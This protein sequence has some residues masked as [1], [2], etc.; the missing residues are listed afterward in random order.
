MALDVF[1]PAVADWFTRAFDGP[2]QVQTQAWPLIAAGEHVLISAPT[3]SGKTLAA[4]LYGLDRLAA[5]PLPDKQRRV[6]LLYVSPLKALSHDVDRNLRAPLAGITAAIGQGSLLPDDRARDGSLRAEKGRDRDAI[7][8]ALRTGDTP[9]RERAA[10]R[11]RPP[12]V[13][14]TTPES[15]FLMLTSGAREMLTGV[16]SLIIDEIH[17]VAGTKRGSHMAL[18]LER[19]SALREPG[20][21]GA[22]SGD[23]MQRIGLS[24]TQNPLEEIGRFLVGP[25]RSCRIVET[26]EKKKMDLQIRVPVESMAEL[27]LA[28]AGTVRRPETDGIDDTTGPA[29]GDQLEPEGGFAP[30][31]G[32]A[33]SV[34]AGD[35]D[36]DGAGSAV[37]AGASTGDAAGLDPD[38]LDLDPAG[39]DDLDLDPGA[40]DAARRGLEAKGAADDLDLDPAGD[41]LEPAAATVDGDDLDD[42]GDDLDPS[43]GGVQLADDPLEPGGDPTHGATRNSIWPAMYPEILDLVQEHRSTIVFVNSRRSAERLALRLNE[44]AESRLAQ[45]ALEAGLGDPNANPDARWDE[46]P[47]EARKRKDSDLRRLIA[48]RDGVV[49][50]EDDPDEDDDDPEGAARERELQARAE[51]AGKA[52]TWA[53]S[54]HHDPDEEI[55]LPGPERH[56]GIQPP[57]PRKPPPVVP[58]QARSS[59]PGSVAA[60]GARRVSAPG[61]EE[62]LRSEAIAAGLAAGLGPKGVPTRDG[63]GP[64]GRRGAGSHPAT[65]PNG[66]PRDA[67]SGGGIAGSQNHVTGVGRPHSDHYGPRDD[68]Q[69][70]RPAPTGPSAV[71]VARAHHGSLSREEREVVEELLKAGKLPCLVA[72]SSLELGIDMGAVDLVLQIESPKSV[73]A[74]LQRIGRAGHGVGETAKGRI[75]PKFRADLLE[76]AVVVR[77]MREGLIEPTVV[78]KNALDVLAQQI[79]AIAASV[80]SDTETTDDDAEPAIAVDDVFA[81][82]T[83][84]YPYADLPREL[85]ERTLDMLD[86]RYPSQDFAELRPRVVWDRVGQTIRPRKG[87]GRLAI[88]NAGTIPDRGMYRVVLP[89]GRRV[90]ELDEEMVYEARAGQTFLLG[91]STWRIEEIGRDKVVVTPAPGAPGA[92]PFW[93][94]DQRGRP[95]ALGE[96][97]GAF[98]RWAVGEDEATLVRDYDLDPLAAR[99]L[100]DFLTEQQDAT[101]VIPSDQTLVIE[102]FKDEIGDWRVCLLSP[103]GGRV[104]AA[105]GLAASRRIRDEM[106]L[107]AD[108]IWSDDGII[109]H[110]PDIDDTGG[111]GVS[112]GDDP[113]EDGF[114]AGK[115]ASA[116]ADAG[117]GTPVGDGDDAGAK[118]AG[119]SGVD[120]GLSLP[121]DGGRG[122]GAGWDRV[123][124]LLVPEPEEVEDLIVSEL[125][126]SALFG[127]RFREN[128][129]RA[130][131][132]PKARPGKR[133][134]L[135]QQRLKAQSLLEVAQTFP[136]F[137][138]ILETYRECLRDVLDVPGLI[139]LLSKLQSREITIVEVETGTASPMA[140]SLLFDYIATYMYE[141]D[142]PN[143]ERRAAALSLDRDLLRELLG[144]D[145]LRDLLDEGALAQLEAD[146]Q[147]RSPKTRARNADALGEVLRRVGDLTDEEI[148]DRVAIGSLSSAAWD[149]DGGRDGRAGGRSDG[150]DGSNGGGPDGGGHATDGDLARASAADGRGPDGAPKDSDIADVGSLE[151][152]RAAATAWLDDLERQRRAIRM[153][154]GGEQRWIAADDAGLYRDALGAVPPGGLPEVF[155][156]DVRDPLRRLVIR[157]AATHGPFVDHELHARYGVDPTAVLRELLREDELVRGEIR[158]GGTETEHCDPEVLRRLRRMSLAVL[159]QEIEPADPRALVSFSQTWQGVDRYRPAGAGPDRLREVLVPLQGLALPVELWEHEVLPRRLG[160]YSPSWLDGLCASGEVVW[161]GAGALGRGGGK[162]AFYFREDSAVIGP[163]TGRAARDASISLPAAGAPMSAGRRALESG[164]PDGSPGVPGSGGAA[165]GPNGSPRGTGPGGQ[166]DQPGP[167]GP[168]HDALRRLLAS[169][170]MFFSDVLGAL[171]EH[172]AHLRDALWDLIWAGEVTCDVFAPLRAGRAGMK[173]QKPQPAAARS[174]IG[175]RAGG[176][177][178]FG[179]RPTGAQT[180]STQGRFSLTAPLFV[181]LDG[182]AVDPGLRRRTLAELLLERHGIVTREHVKAEGIAGG[183]STLYDSFGALETLGVCRRGYFVEGL[184]GAQF[185]LPGAVERLR[186]QAVPDVHGPDGEVNAVDSLG[187]PLPATTLDATDPAQPYGTLLPWPELPAPRGDREEGARTTQL[188]RPSTANEPRPQRAQGAR[189]VLVGPDPILFVDRSGKALQVLVHYDD[190]RLP[191]AFAALVEA[192]QTGKAGSLPRKGLQLERIDGLEVIGHPLEPLLVPA[193]FRSAPTKYLARA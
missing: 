66:A 18:T 187:R 21:P 64:D 76:C 184:G 177:R 127:A 123:L 68:T 84:A 138:I 107:E 48:T 151:E 80:D 130:L 85:F 12:D 165:A 157:Y 192:I 92:V 102:R 144:Q 28:P 10:M 79:V 154:I 75:F 77:R 44:L 32:T 182:G 180:T 129:G 119:G 59:L 47:D 97:I 150:A 8:V 122:M 25:K 60:E 140:S 104:H 65:A 183:F 20:Q 81:L 156:N 5:N 39:A 19:L 181:P 41:A 115:A 148:L 58:S 2:T 121:D 147:H 186:G 166:A 135:W 91:A 105:W 72:T 6:R 158:P 175:T 27:D 149:R 78:P 132:I 36:C 190:P 83:R 86:G 69:P 124:E 126:T 164:G 109:I 169:R 168:V 50:G 173:A 171:P 16:E 34:D 179:P 136:D 43:A 33:A 42:L 110:L 87:A 90:G 131:L 54:R 163:P 29:S 46:D 7:K 103:Y 51:A 95:K 88:A 45:A 193:G 57:L 134:P 11:R 108:A 155:L 113:F 67:D 74:G 128:A 15:L 142:A 82:V 99:N 13:L 40:V 61:E 100:L 161:V 14:I 111:Q 98:S 63:G 96:A 143:A 141:G 133:T 22:W 38:D 37:G 170:S 94:G 112:F 125:G 162:V 52:G 56:A 89:D 55:T 178:R 137:P 174:G 145:E 117:F 4:F 101:G 188:E 49:G 146:L 23:E 93:R 17:A 9:Q 31:A 73:A 160:A 172:T 167:S 153:R 24:A 1:T 106:G 191:I 30:G 189:V 53:A 152:R 35:G 185:A 70:D 116:V 26:G 159:R 62:L 118:A 176:R 120:A 71:E 139:D 114:D 3:G